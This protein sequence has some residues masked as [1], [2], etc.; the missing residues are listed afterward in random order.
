ML[1]VKDTAGSFCLH[2]VQRLMRKWG[3]ESSKIKTTVVS[4]ME[5]RY[6]VRLAE[7]GSSSA[8]VTAEA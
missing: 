8:K 6:T 4:T 3:K 1:G 2:G 7:R 5:E